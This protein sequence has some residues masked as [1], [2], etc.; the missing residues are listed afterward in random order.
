[1]AFACYWDSFYTAL[2]KLS[3][4]KDDEEIYLYKGLFA[5]NIVGNSVG[6]IE[7]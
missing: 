6:F 3:K 5:L 2:D 7:F 4:C 1:M